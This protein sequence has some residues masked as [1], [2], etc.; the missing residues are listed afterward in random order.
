[1]SR[2]YGLNAYEKRMSRNFQFKT[3][4]NYSNNAYS[5]IILVYV[6]AR[7]PYLKKAGSIPLTKTG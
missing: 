7:S 4:Q 2:K 6:Y 1:M 3:P 5:Y